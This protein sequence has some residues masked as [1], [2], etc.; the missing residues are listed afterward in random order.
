MISASQRPL[1]SIGMPVYNCAEVLEVAI[2]SILKQT[3]CDWELLLIDDGS[4]DRT[5]DL[6]RS[7][8][9]RRIR[10]FA[11]GSHRALVRRLNEAVDLSRGK[12]FARM[13]GD[14]VAYSER[15]ELQVRFLEENPGIDLVGGGI[16]VF[17]GD[18]E[19]LGIRRIIQNHAEICQ[20][21]WAGF[22]LPHPT[23]MGRIEWFRTNRYREK[24]VRSEDQDLLLRTYSTSQFASLPETLLGY[25]ESSLSLRKMLRA[26]Y[27]FAKAVFEVFLSKRAYRTAFRGVLEQGLKAGVDV[28]AVATGLNYHI[29]R[30]RAL[31]ASQETLQRWSTV[32]AHLQSLA[33]ETTAGSEQSSGST[34]KHCV[35]QR[36]P[37]MANRA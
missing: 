36:E 35:K 23:W 30:H 13:D 18:G 21:P 10:L 11:D 29:L 8:A 32:W 2:R 27:S 34:N 24:A 37:G 4:T 31:P 28:F 16:L 9:D 25:Q 20:R 1:V 12:Y 7:F 5:P 26:R 3:F 15:L 33:D 19:A 17:R 6:C 14:D 22:Y